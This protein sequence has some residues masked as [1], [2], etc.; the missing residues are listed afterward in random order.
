MTTEE[1]KEGIVLMAFG[2]G[3][4]SADNVS[5]DKYIGIGTFNVV[6][7]NPTK[8]EMSAIFNRDFE[9][10]PEYLGKDDKTNVDTIRI[11]ILVKSNSEK[12]PGIDLITKVPIFLKNEYRLNKDKTK[13]QVINKYGETAW[14]TEA[15]FKAQEVPANIKD[16]FT[17]PYRECYVGEEELT[18]FLKTFLSIPARS[19]KN[20]DQ[21]IVFIENPADAEARLENIPQ[22]FKGNIKEI[23]E[24]ISM[25]PNNKVVLPIGIKTTADN[26]QYYDVFTKLIMKSNAVTAEGVLTTRMAD[27]LDNE[28]KASKNSGSYGNTEFSLAPLHVYKVEATSFT[29][30]AQSSGPAPAGNAAPKPTF[31]SFFGGGAP[32]PAPAASTDAGD[33]LPF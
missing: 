2:G 14:V 27:K 19:Y 10:E 33:D 17:G 9:K 28:I 29:T 15:E 24:L 7:V 20:K 4:E 31:G 5:F 21:K 26:K 23:K 6:G 18:S 13:V 12:H 22:Y 16:W 25:Q 30:G 11:E 3:R 32:S 8:A 1:K